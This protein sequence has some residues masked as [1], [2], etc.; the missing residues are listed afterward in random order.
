MITAFNS[1]SLFDLLKWHLYFKIRVTSIHLNF[2]KIFIH[3][4]WYAFYDNKHSIPYMKAFTWLFKKSVQIS[5]LLMYL[6]SRSLRDNVPKV[7]CVRCDVNG[8]ECAMSRSFSLVDV[9]Y[10]RGFLFSSLIFT[11]NE[12]RLT[13]NWTLK[14]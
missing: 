10:K 12:S 9:H 4:E 1:L 11:I 13:T 5:F 6:W 3:V 2:R 7:Y 14:W 8:P